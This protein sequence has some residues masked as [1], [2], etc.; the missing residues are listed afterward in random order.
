MAR[1][2]QKAQLTQA[3]KCIQKAT[4][5]FLLKPA[6]LNSYAIGIPKS[7]VNISVHCTRLWCACRLRRCWQPSYIFLRG[8]RRS[9][10]PAGTGQTQTDRLSRWARGLLFHVSRTSIPPYGPTATAQRRRTDGTPL[11][12]RRG[13]Q[14]SSDLPAPHATSGRLADRPHAPRVPSGIGRNLVFKD[15]IPVTTCARCSRCM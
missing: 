8:L 14:S 5:W 1:R 7:A 10:W 9:V 11:R 13:A 12:A 3:A 4:L 15:P 2:S 6:N